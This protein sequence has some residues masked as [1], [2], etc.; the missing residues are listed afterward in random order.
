[1]SN[2]PAP[3]PNPIEP[4]PYASR[5][6]ITLLMR[7]YS[8]VGW[9]FLLSGLCSLASAVASALIVRTSGSS[10]IATTSQLMFAAP[11]SVVAIGG[12]GMIVREKWGAY[13]LIG[14]A[15]FRTL[16]AG[17]SMLLVVAPSRSIGIYLS[18]NNSA[19][20]AL[21]AFATATVAYLL[22]RLCKDN[23]AFGT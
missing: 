9:Y 14:A 21:Q 13:V 18:L 7:A 10:I 20:Q 19:A 5:T 1:M 6:E 22:L 23:N 3:A 8:Y 2:D 16:V 17:A 4:L 12:I 11:M 15:I